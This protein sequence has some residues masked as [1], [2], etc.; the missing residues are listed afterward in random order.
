M[1]AADGGE[2]ER[3]G[4]RSDDVVE[5]GIEIAHAKLMLS[6]K[7][8]SP[9]RRWVAIHKHENDSDKVLKRGFH[10]RRDGDIVRERAGRKPDQFRQFVC[11]A[12]RISVANTVF[13]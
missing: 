12:N 13:D 8:E 7:P 11:Q 2:E 4:L 9:A 3:V 1:R 5:A 6:R 10:A